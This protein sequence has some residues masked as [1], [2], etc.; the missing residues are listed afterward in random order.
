MC[1]VIYL[2]ILAVILSAVS[3]M[4]VILESIF[5]FVL[6]WMMDIFKSKSVRLPLGEVL[7]LILRPR[8]PG[9]TGL[10]LYSEW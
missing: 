3:S 4:G 10:V 6:W 1:I 2:K 5:L 9:E 8:G 7:F